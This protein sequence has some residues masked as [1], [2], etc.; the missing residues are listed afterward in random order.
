LDPF[1]VLFSGQSRVCDR[2]TVFFCSL[3]FYRSLNNALSHQL[4]GRQLT[5]QPPGGHIGYNNFYSPNATTD[6]QLHAFNCTVSLFTVYSLY[7]AVH[8][9]FVQ[10]RRPFVSAER[11]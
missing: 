3:A 7:I 8:T 9:V 1:I 5:P 4:F 2:L 10:V 6:V 11:L